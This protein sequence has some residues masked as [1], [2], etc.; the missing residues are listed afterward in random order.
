[1]FLNR[2]HMLDI[3]PVCDYHFYLKTVEC[4]GADIFKSHGELKGF[5]NIYRI[6]HL[7]IL[8]GSY[9]AFWCRQIGQSLVL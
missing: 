1:M 6:L 8:I 5:C 9:A 7:E 4:Y 3:I 2:N